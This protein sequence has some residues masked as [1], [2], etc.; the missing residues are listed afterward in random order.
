MLIDAHTHLSSIIRKGEKTTVEEIM[1]RAAEVGVGYVMT[2]SDDMAESEEAV[3][4]A[5]LSP[6][7]YCALAFHPTNAHELDETC[8]KRMAELV[9]DPKCLAIGETG[10]DE[11][12]IGKMESCPELDVQEEAFRWHI[13]LARDVDKPVMI[14]SR[15]ADENLLRVLKDEELP[16]EVMLH[17]FSSPMETAK[18]ALDLGCVL[19]FCG[20]TTFKRND[21]L[22]EIAA[23]A[24]LDRI[25]VE[26]DAPF[27][28][29]EPLRGRRNEPSHIVHT[30]QC[31]ADARG[32]PRAALEEAVEQ[33]FHRMFRV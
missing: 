18:Q 31:I 19:S 33:N 24:P 23:Y 29:P 9:Q 8:R 14:H 26:T 32:I 17:C 13:G 21:Y 3:K 1:A 5:H 25:L 30:Y 11:Y 4:H 12:W 22:R 20:N 7:I 6:N 28:S 27:M 16:R 10:L 2:V 15:D